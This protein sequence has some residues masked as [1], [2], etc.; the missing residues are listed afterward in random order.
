MKTHRV[1]CKEKREDSDR[2]RMRKKKKSNNHFYIPRVVSTVFGFSLPSSL[3][4]LS[5]PHVVVS[6]AVVVVLSNS[7]LSLPNLL[8]SLSLPNLQLPSLP[9]LSLLLSPTSRHWL[10]FAVFYTTTVS[11]QVNCHKDE[12][13]FFSPYIDTNIKHSRDVWR[14]CLLQPH[15]RFCRYPIFTFPRV[16]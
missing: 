10:V 2:E 14:T 5:L 9:N 15:P 4:P 1:N 8:L 13:H 16:H 11:N 3:L 6:I 7:S 12:T